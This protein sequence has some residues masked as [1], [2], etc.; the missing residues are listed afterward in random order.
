LVRHLE[1][2]W[3]HCV[4]AGDV[5]TGQDALALNTH[6]DVDVIITN[7]PY[8]RP[9]IRAQIWHFARS[10]P[11]WLLI[12]TD[13]PPPDRPRPSRCCVPTSC[14]W[15]ACDTEEV[16]VTRGS[17][18]EATHMLRDLNKRPE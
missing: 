13:G 16:A 7:P 12:K 8:T 4:Y 9:L 5:A 10:L 14:W 1:V 18:R 17:L 6:G 11:T 15:A 2:L 3:L